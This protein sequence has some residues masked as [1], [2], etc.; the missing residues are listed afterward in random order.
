MELV[1]DTIDFSDYMREPDDNSNV[2]PASHW[3][4]SVIDRFNMPE[5]QQGSTLPWAKTH[6]NFRFRPG[7]VTLWPGINGHGKS[8]VVGHSAL[9]LM[10]DGERVCVA[11]MEMKPVA[12]VSRMC[13]Q[14]SG[15]S[16]PGMAFV[17]Q[18]SKWTDEKLWIYDQLGTVKS[19]RLLAVMRYC[20]DK[21]HITHFVIDSLMKCGI[22]EDDYNRQKSFLD[23]LC[24]YARDTACHVHLIAHSRKTQDEFG[25][26]NKMDVKGTG[27]ITDQVDNV[28]T[29]WRNKRKEADVAKCESS[30][31]I[32]SAEIID[33]PDALVICDK[34]RHGEW[35]GRISLWFDRDSFQYLGARDHRAHQFFEFIS[36]AAA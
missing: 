29:V 27:A 22:A 11:S 33:K 32:P 7:E 12:T 30:N 25:V 2:R 4:Q 15:V 19:D 8:M 3:N 35:E 1:P 18:F 21:L 23:Q 34:Q 26:P 36:A 9:R 28:L 20:A 6:R 14:A 13:R 17:R 16:D 24:A 31:T 10:A 5:E